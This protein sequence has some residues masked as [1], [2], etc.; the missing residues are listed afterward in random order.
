MYYKMLTKL[1]PPNLRV[2]LSH[3]HLQIKSEDESRLEGNQE[4]MVVSTP[5]S[6]EVFNAVMQKPT[7]HL[8]RNLTDSR[9]FPLN[10]AT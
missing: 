8:G 7:L 4:K 9:K 10:R 3:Q 6:S 5:Q 1:L 2:T